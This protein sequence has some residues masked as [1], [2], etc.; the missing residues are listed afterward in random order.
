MLNKL[1]PEINFC[2]CGCEARLVKEKSRQ[3][4]GR[5]RYKVQCLD[6]VCGKQSKEL[7]FPWQA[8]LEWNQSSNSEFPDDFGLPFMTFTG[9]SAEEIQATMQKKFNEIA[10]DIDKLQANRNGKNNER[11]KELRLKQSWLLYGQ[12]WANDKFG[13]DS[14][15]R[16]AAN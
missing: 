2:S 7:P 11:L 10:K 6:D 12:S 4:K 15:L 1:K 3:G 9:M 13:L 8:I 16:E 5:F 14:D